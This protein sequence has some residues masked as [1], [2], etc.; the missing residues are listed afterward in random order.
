MCFYPSFFSFQLFIIILFL[1]F[2][3]SLLSFPRRMNFYSSLIFSIFFNYFDFL[4]FFGLDFHLYFIFLKK[5]C[6]I[7]PSFFFSLFSFFSC[8]FIQLCYFYSKED[9]FY[10][11]FSLTFFSFWICFPMIISFPLFSPLRMWSFSWFSFA[12]KLPFC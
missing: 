10:P 5:M 12:K 4:F 2:F 3:S 8:Y 1:W 7:L 6:F 9:L 11:S